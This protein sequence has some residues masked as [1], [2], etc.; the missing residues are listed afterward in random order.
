MEHDGQTGSL[1]DSE[2]RARPGAD[3]PSRVRAWLALEL[4]FE[5]GSFSA[6]RG[7]GEGTPGRR[8]G[9]SRGLEVGGTQQGE[10]TGSQ[11]AG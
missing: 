1:R 8:T 2:G 11:P 10:G 9:M 5:G 7:R 3:G 4:G 6:G